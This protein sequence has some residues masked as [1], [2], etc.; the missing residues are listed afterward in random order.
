MASI[1]APPEPLPSVAEVA[2]KILKRIGQ[3]FRRVMQLG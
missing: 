3:F 1:P 2:P